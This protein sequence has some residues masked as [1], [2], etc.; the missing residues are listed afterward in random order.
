MSQGVRV[1]GIGE[2]L[3]E[4]AHATTDRPFVSAYQFC[5]V[6]VGWLGYA[7]IPPRCAYALLIEAFRKAT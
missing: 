2:M 4:T 5:F 6:I 1:A 3:V 7:S